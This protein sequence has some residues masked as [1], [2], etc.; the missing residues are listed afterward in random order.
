MVVCEVPLQDDDD[1]NPR[2]GNSE[3]IWLH[4]P[5]KHKAG[6]SFNG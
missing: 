2:L 3:L 5:A 4:S 6:I 1:G